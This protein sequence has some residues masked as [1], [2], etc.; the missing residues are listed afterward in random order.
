MSCA[1][2][3]VRGCHKYQTVKLG[4][5]V[6]APVLFARTGPRV[7]MIRPYSWRLPVKKAKMFKL[8]DRVQATDSAGGKMIGKIVDPTPYMRDAVVKQ[9]IRSG[10]FMII[11]KRPGGFNFQHFAMPRDLRAVG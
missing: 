9:A 2:A 11:G 4:R 10:R 6:R 8:G 3:A 1:V 5:G 7:L